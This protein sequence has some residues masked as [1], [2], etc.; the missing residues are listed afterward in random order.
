MIAFYS[1]LTR[2]LVMLPV[3]VRALGT[4]EN[5]DLSAVGVSHRNCERKF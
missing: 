2:V 3:V 4:P 1:V 5:D